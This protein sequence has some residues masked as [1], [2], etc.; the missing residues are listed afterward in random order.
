VKGGDRARL[1]VPEDPTLREV[2]AAWN[3]A[4]YFAFAVDEWWRIVSLSA[5][6]A[7]V[8]GDERILGA[9]LYGPE[10]IDTQLRG[11]AGVNAAEELRENFREVGCWLLADFGRDALRELV[12]PI[13]RD[14]IDDLEP[15]DGAALALE[16]PTTAYGSSIASTAVYERVRDSTGRVV[17]TVIVTKPAVGMNTLFLLTAPGDLG[18]FERMRQVAAA[19]RRPAAVLFADLEGSAALAKRLPT[20]DYFR[21]VRRLTRAAD[22]CVVD[23]GGL[24]G[25]HI[26]DGVSAFFVAETAGSESAAARACIEALQA[27]RV[28]LHDLAARHDLSEDEPA[29]RAGL[30]WGT[31][32]Y[33]GSIITRGRT[34]VT[35]LGD[36]VNEAARIEACA[37]GGRAL[38][39]KSL[40]ERLSFEDATAL[41]IDPARITYTQLANLDT[42]TDKA[43][44]DAPSIPVYDVADV[45][46]LSAP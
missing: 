16:R 19:G 34:E 26:G 20:A 22:A 14:L 37:T 24:V 41:G 23:A 32:L 44:R 3:D 28:A 7:E 40:L 6:L 27:L 33:I 15:R 39:S 17:G 29:I 46:G 30:H 31:T 36:E 35:A 2:I 4:G 13:F 21:L 18:H 9:F 38:A 12:H 1:G 45:A 42:A 10:Q 11:S 43:R 25:R 5:E 8:I